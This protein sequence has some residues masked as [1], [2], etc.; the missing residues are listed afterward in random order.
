MFPLSQ[1]LSSLSYMLQFMFV[2]LPTHAE[3]DLGKK[4]N[5]TKDIYA[6]QM[7]FFLYLCSTD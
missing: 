2:C 7:N 3:Y 6:Q 1:N 5:T 4:L